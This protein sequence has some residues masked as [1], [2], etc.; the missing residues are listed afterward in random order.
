M[1]ETLLLIPT[2]I[3]SAQNSPAKYPLVLFPLIVLSVPGVEFVTFTSF[4]EQT[5]ASVIAM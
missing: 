4:L 1:A 2:A 5:L 3:S